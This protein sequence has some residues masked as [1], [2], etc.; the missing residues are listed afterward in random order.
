MLVIFSL[1]VLTI[2]YWWTIPESIRWLLAKRRQEDAKNLLRKVA[3]LNS[4]EF[5]DRMLENIETR[6]DESKVSFAQII[7]SRVL[8][9]RFVL[10]CSA[11]LGIFFLYFGF[12]LNSVSLAGDPYLD[13]TLQTL[14]EIPGCILP[15]CVVDKF[16][17]R[18]S[19]SAS[20]FFTAVVCFVFVMIPKGKTRA[21]F[22]YKYLIKTLVG[23]YWLRISVYLLEKLGAT[24]AV[25]IIG[26]ITNEIFPTTV[27]HS[28]FSFCSTIGH[29]GSTL[30]VQMPLLVKTNL[31]C[32]LKRKTSLLDKLQKNHPVCSAYF[33]SCVKLS[34]KTYKFAQCVFKTPLKCHVGI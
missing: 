30:A 28:L 18:S 17:R 24:V 32:L 10:C 21:I 11:W 23:I 29:V 12:V 15:L 19:L 33:P 1:P 2:T 31:F 9:T 8:L 16:G 3:K 6:K 22:I 34:V 13:F 20:L 26:V 27:R 14:V 5:S 25:T 7:N 4:I